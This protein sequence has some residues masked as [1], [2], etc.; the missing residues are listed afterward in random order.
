LVSSQLGAGLRVDLDTPAGAVLMIVPRIALGSSYGQQSYQ[1]RNRNL[2]ATKASF[3]GP[4]TEFELPREWL[5]M[6]GYCRTPA[7]YSMNFFVCS[8]RK[9]S[10]NI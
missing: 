3:A 6:A 2:P 10:R 8:Q 4:G 7:P 5:F 1:R 9:S